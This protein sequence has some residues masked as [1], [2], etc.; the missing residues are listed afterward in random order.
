[1]GQCCSSEEQQILSENFRSKYVLLKCSWWGTRTVQRRRTETPA[2]V[3]PFFGIPVQA[4]RD[5]FYLR[6]QASWLIVLF[7]IFF[8]L[9]VNVPCFKN[10][11]FFCQWP[12]ILH[13]GDFGNSIFIHWIM[14][15][16]R[17]ILAAEWLVF[18]GSC[19]KI[20]MREKYVRQQKMRRLW[21]SLLLHK[22]VNRNSEHKFQYLPLA[23]SQ[24]QRHLEFLDICLFL[25]ISLSLI[26]FLTNIHYPK[27]LNY[28]LKE[29]P[30]TCEDLL[31]TSLWT[32]SK[33]CTL[34]QGSETDFCY[35]CRCLKE[36]ISADNLL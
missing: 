4:V 17:D 1:M 11:C 33:T 15:R 8:S 29:R 32:W 22:W 9:K 23:A 2:V 25:T 36:P 6:V 27:C 30:H 31:I 21:V 14:W 18:R 34:T 35:G 26:I 3:Q 19:V 13:Y 24:C 12:V 5:Y 20:Q 10:N 7:L 28:P 16:Y